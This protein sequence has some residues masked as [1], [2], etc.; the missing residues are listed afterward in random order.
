MLV[1]N[2]VQDKISAKNHYLNTYR[3]RVWDLLE[4]FLI[5]NIVVIPRK[6]NQV[7]YALAKRGARL[8][9]TF[10]KRGD[11][12]VKV[13]CRPS[14]LDTTNYWQVFDSYDHIMN[15]LVDEVISHTFDV[16]ELMDYFQ[17]Y[18]VI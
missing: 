3:N 2:Q 4:S 7:A 11:H 1:I 14:I 12:G 10:Y 5:I 8:N 15:F 6:Y 13:L 18:D 9:P 17:E 16:Q